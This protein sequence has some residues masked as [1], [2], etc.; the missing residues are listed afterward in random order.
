MEQPWSGEKTVNSFNQGM[1]NVDI[2]VLCQLLFWLQWWK[3]WVLLCASAGWDESVFGV[4]WV[5]A[6]FEPCEPQNVA[7]L[8]QKT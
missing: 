6:G 2:P 7:I 4:C 8:A 5:T 3:P 1:P